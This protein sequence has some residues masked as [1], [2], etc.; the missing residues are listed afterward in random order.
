MGVIDRGR[1]E[2]IAQQWLEA[3]NAHRADLVVAHF[4]ADV[5]AASP[6]IDRLRP[7]SGGRLT[8]RDAVRDYYE[9]GLRLNTDL[10]FILVEVLC[11]VDQLTIV[12]RN[13]RGSLVAE[14][15]TVG[16]D[17]VVTAVSVAYG[18]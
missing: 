18:P 3:F 10:H 13:Q 1:A 8:G 11:G 14:T 16:N 5:T 9:E 7:G 17:D 15:L 6:L 12:Y 2:R 4:A